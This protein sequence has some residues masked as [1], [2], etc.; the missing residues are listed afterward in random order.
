ME[1]ITG[2]SC[3]T[4]KLEVYGKDDGLVCTLTDNDHLLGSYQIDDG[5]RLHVSY[6][7]VSVV[8]FTTLLSFESLSCLLIVDYL[9]GFNAISGD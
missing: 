1:V 2:A 7:M 5:M 8:I 4:M 6:A 3:S 9:K